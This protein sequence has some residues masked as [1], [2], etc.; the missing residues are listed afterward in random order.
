MR[1]HTCFICT[2]LLLLLLLMLLLLG[3][4]AYDAAELPQQ[5]TGLHLAATTPRQQQQLW[6]LRC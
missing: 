5:Q 3:D 1:Q 4:V 2:L 6:L